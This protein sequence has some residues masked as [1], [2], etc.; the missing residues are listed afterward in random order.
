MKFIAIAAIAIVAAQEEEAAAEV[1]ACAEGECNVTDAETM[2]T[3]C[4]VV[5]EG[6]TVCDPEAAPTEEEGSTTLFASVA[7]V[8]VAA[9]LMY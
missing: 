7:A 6:E 2:E 5:V 3:T 9:T 4:T 8:A 1:A